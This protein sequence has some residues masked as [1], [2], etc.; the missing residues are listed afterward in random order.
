[1][2]DMN[3]RGRKGTKKCEYFQPLICTTLSPAAVS[4]DKRN[5]P[6]HMKVRGDYLSAKKG[7]TAGRTQKMKLARAFL[8]LVRES[9]HKGLVG[10]D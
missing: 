2:Q 8:S 6:H 3:R 10:I 9:S 4:E 1:M 5:R 7:P